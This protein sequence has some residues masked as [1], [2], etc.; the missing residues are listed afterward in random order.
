MEI[1]LKSWRNSLAE[2]R[3]ENPILPVVL[4]SQEETKDQ[5]LK[6]EDS[7][8]K[9]IFKEENQSSILNVTKITKPIVSQI[10]W[11][12]MSTN[13]LNCQKAVVSESEMKDMLMDQQRKIIEDMISQGNSIF[14][15]FINFYIY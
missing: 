12:S 13:I 11:P 15:V 3:S 9:L 6:T 2:N 4:K 5:N 10:S 14:N 7:E 1:K 8:P